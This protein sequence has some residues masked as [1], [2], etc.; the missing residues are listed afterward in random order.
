MPPTRIRQPRKHPQG[1]EDTSPQQQAPQNG[2]VW[3]EAGVNLP[4]RYTRQAPPSI[5]P[6][7]LATPGSLITPLESGWRALGLHMR[8]LLCGVDSNGVEE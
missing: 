3:N 4:C 7:H 2:G 5:E 1:P 6:P 8:T